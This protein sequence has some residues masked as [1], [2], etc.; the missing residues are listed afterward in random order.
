MSRI[1]RKLGFDRL[2]A[3]S[4]FAAVFIV[5]VGAKPGLI[6]P[7]S[8]QLEDLAAASCSV[9]CLTARCDE[10]DFSWHQAL[11]GGSLDELDHGS[12]SE[13]WDESC[14]WYSDTGYHDQCGSGLAFARNGDYELLKRALDATNADDLHELISRYP[15]VLKVNKSRGS[16]Q[17]AGCDGS[18]IAN[19][20][21]SA[22]LL[23]EVLSH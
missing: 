20:P 18:V 13:C 16:I 23:K 2:V 17:V 11:S 14:G 12:H 9:T 22:G 4:L 5:S 10:F 21:M 19:H 6:P 3:L 7:S 1:A 8:P 15:N